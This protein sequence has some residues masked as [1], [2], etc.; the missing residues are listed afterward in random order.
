MFVLAFVLT[1]TS[2]VLVAQSN[3][4]V[5]DRPTL[6]SSSVPF[7]STT[8][9]QTFVFSLERFSRAK[10]GLE[11]YTKAVRLEGTPLRF[12]VGYKVAW[13]NYPWLNVHLRAI[14]DDRKDFSFVGCGSVIVVNQFNRSDDT[15]DRRWAINMKYYGESVGKEVILLSGP[16]VYDEK[17]GW[18]NKDKDNVLLQYEFNHFKIHV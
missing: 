13:S 10:N 4:S 15:E 12:Y 14:H 5:V 11:Q 2:Y 6:F 18:Y 7:N 17:E 9:N 8:Q 3:A 1:L 16:E